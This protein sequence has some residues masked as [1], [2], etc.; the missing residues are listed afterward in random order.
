MNLCLYAQARSVT[1]SQLL[2]CHPSLHLVR[3][4]RQPYSKTHPMHSRNLQ[5]P[6][7]NDK[8]TEILQN[9][10]TECQNL[11]VIE[12]KHQTFDEISHDQVWM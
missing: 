9:S 7:Y 11:F 1:C 4:R 10:V 12:H 5:Q 8:Q 2:M 3:T 6:A